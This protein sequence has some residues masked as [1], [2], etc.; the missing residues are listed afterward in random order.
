MAKSRGEW[1]EPCELCKGCSWGEREARR[2]CGQEGRDDVR[3]KV[4]AVCVRAEHIV[5]PVQSTKLVKVL[6]I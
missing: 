4:G 6:S 3:L 1:S 2:H 5:R